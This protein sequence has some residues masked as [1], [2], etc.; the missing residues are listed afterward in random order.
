M[1]AIIAS[2]FV[3]TV[4]GIYLSVNGGEEIVGIRPDFQNGFYFGSGFDGSDPVIAWN[5]SK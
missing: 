3:L 1:R 4:A 2:L 5:P